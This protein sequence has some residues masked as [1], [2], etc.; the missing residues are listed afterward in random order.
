MNFHNLSKIS[1]TLG[2]VG[3][4]FFHSI[5]LYAEKRGRDNAKILIFKPYSYINGVEGLYFY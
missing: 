3:H 2:L 4:T 5:I 1:M